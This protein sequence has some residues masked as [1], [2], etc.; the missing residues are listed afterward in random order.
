MKL[1]AQCLAVGVLAQVA[2]GEPAE[3][4][5]VARGTLATGVK[6]LNQLVVNLDGVKNS[7]YLSVPTDAELG[8][9]SGMELIAASHQ[10]WRMTGDI[11][12]VR[13]HWDT[14]KRALESVKTANDKVGKQGEAPWRYM[15]GCHRLDAAKLM[16]EMARKLGESEFADQCFA[17]VDAER[18]SLQNGFLDPDG[19]LVPELRELPAAVVYALKC[20]LVEDEAREQT[21]AAL[22]RT[23]AK[24]G[25]DMLASVPTSFM[26]QILAE[27]DSSEVAYALVR[28]LKP[29]QLN[30]SACGA[31]LDW[32]FGTMAGI[33]PGPRGGFDKMVELS[34]TPDRRTGF[35]E[36]TYRNANGVIKSAWRYDE[37]GRCRWKFSIPE[38]TRATVC[39]NG[40]C[41]PYKSGDW[42]LEIK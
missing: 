41:R 36:A 7:R 38:G 26:L 24:L 12:I 21:L 23:A 18:E 2:L 20:E 42:E 9:L 25:S 37:D 39:V 31:L 8:R 6:E 30:P 35:V 4:N 27:E 15:N 17:S 13:R 40:M 5:A 10:A 1:F 19:M 22:K 3:S 33:Q 16:G 11:A 34:P 28:Q 14:L 29:S 32:M